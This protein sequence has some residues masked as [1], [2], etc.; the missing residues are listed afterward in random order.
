MFDIIKIFIELFL[1]F[2]QESFSF[3]ILLYLPSLWFYFGCSLLIHFY[4]FGLS[5]LWF[6]QSCLFLFFKKFLF[7]TFCFFA[8][9]DCCIFD[10]SEFIGTNDHG[11]LLIVLFSLFPNGS[12]FIQT[13]HI[14]SYVWSFCFS[15]KEGLINKGILIDTSRTLACSRSNFWLYRNTRN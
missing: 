4:H 14:S 6:G 10:P 7:C 3:F 2:R 13:N 11:I 9:N 15:T 12:K 5:S 8:L 1:G